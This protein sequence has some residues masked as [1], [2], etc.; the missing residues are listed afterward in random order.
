MVI[1]C[2]AELQSWLRNPTH[3]AFLPDLLQRQIQLGIQLRDMVEADEATYED[4]IEGILTGD[5]DWD[6]IYKASIRDYDTG[7]VP[8]DK[9]TEKKQYQ[10]HAQNWFKSEEGGRELAWKV[11]SLGVWPVLQPQLM[12]FCNAVRKAL[13]LAEITDLKP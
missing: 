13:D 8:D 12:P 10:S 4:L 3:Q 6:R 7:T 11:F 2:G 1:L 9:S 5:R